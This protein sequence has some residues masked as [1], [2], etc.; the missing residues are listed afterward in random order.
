MTEPV[1]QEP[2]PVTVQLTSEQVKELALW[3]IFPHDLEMLAKANSKTIESYYLMAERL[4]GVLRAKRVDPEDVEKLAR[5]IKGV[6]GGL[7]EAT[8]VSSLA[9]GGPDRVEHR[10]IRIEIV[11]PAQ[12]TEGETID[13]TPVE[14]KP[15]G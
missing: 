14:V 4:V 11:P 5:A 1:Q 12:L 7:G 6:T 10:R 13:V 2:E 3:G 9:Q 8:R 15:N